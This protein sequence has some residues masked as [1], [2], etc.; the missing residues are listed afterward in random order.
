VSPTLDSAIVSNRDLVRLDLE[1]LVNDMTAKGLIAAGLAWLVAVA[2]WVRFGD[3]SFSYVW[4]AN[5]P[6]KQA[7][8][9][10]GIRLFTILYLGFL[11][12]WLMPLGLGIYR[13]VRHR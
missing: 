12:G 4:T 13:F 5:N 11:I 9:I 10:V 7:A 3:R 1:V 8:L 2:A 6:F